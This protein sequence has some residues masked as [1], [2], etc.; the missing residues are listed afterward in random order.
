MEWVVIGI[1]VA[2][3]LGF[4]SVIIGVPAMTTGALYLKLT[5]GAKEP[6]KGLATLAPSRKGNV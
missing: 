6:P 2:A 5:G 3:N 1:L 4:I